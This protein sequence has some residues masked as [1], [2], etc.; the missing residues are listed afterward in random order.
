MQNASFGDGL[1]KNG[2]AV[3][4]SMYPR[5]VMIRTIPLDGTILELFAITKWTFE[6]QMCGIQ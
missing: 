2:K 6:W 5:Y 4:A 3:V 1:V